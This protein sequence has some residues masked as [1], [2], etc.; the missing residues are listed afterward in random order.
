MSEPGPERWRLPG[1]LEEN[2]GL[3]VAVAARYCRRYAGRARLPFDDAYQEAA[4]AYLRACKYF[5]PARGVKFSSYAADCMWYEIIKADWNAGLIRVSSRLFSKKNRPEG[6]KCPEVYLHGTM[7]NDQTEGRELPPEE[8]LITNEVQPA[9]LR[10]LR[11]IPGR[12]AEVV[13]RYFGLCGH[14][15]ETLSEIGDHF[16]VSKARVQQICVGAL[17]RL[18]TKLP[19]WE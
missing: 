13:C 14:E 16:G 1:R 19:E 3:V 17:R 6:F 8:V 7:H 10:A 4:V 18:R 5:D 11:S 2:L 9:V 15:R 12:Y